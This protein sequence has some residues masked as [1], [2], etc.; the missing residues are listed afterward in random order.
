[1]KAGLL[2]LALVATGALAAPAKL[3]HLD[4]AAQRH[5]GVVTAPLAA[6][7]PA[8]GAT[9]FARALDPV[10]LATLD[11]DIAVAASALAASQAQAART[12][13]LYA[14]DKTVSKQV[15][16]VAQA[17]ARGDAAR[18]TLLHRRLALEWSPALAAM[19]DARRGAL[20]G[21]VA[22]GRAA[23]VRIDA[24]SAMRAGSMVTLDLG[25]GIGARA[26]VLG[27][28]RSGD[29]RVQ[30]VG[31]LGV[32]RGSAALRLGTSAVA[33][34]KLASGTGPT[35]VLIPRAAL[36][37]TGGQAFA[38]VLSGPASFERRAVAGSAD[39]AGF[40]VMSGFRPGERVVVSGAA[41]LFA[42]ETP[43]QHEADD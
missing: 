2:V 13:S 27:P 18:L 4:A 43:S 12:R 9:G 6:A 24:P 37:R 17:Q 36:L 5:M 35:G 39:P 16:D 29:P 3:L 32:V 14:A 23:L 31:Q 42:A 19:S 25:R 22:A 26:S 1:M 10:P 34:V 7:R 11:S 41:Q 8:A 20:I 21:D 30:S 40:V 33:T 38:Y 15:A 28:L